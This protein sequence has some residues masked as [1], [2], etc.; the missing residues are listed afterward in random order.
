MD[1]TQVI[2]WLDE[3]KDAIASIGLIVSGIWAVW[4]WKKKGGNSSTGIQNQNPPNSGKQINAPVTVNGHATVNQQF[5]DTHHHGLSFD[6]AMKLAEKLAAEKG[7][8]DAQFIKSLQ[9][10]IQA[11]TLVN[12]KKYDIKQAFELLDQGDTT[13]AETIFAGVAA[14]ARQAGKE[15]SISEAEAL[16]HLGSLAFLHDTQKAFAAYKRSTELDPKSLN[17]WDGLMRNTKDLI[18]LIMKKNMKEL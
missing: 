9:E 6:D 1:V 11:L 5:G 14:E 4:V 18:F 8:E 10:T 7:E 15:A 13:Q 12:T 17:G 16:R 3:H 2:E